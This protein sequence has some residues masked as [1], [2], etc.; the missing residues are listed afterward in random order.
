[1]LKVAMIGA[2][3]Y[4]YELIK[5]MWKIPDKYK[6]IAVSSSL[7][8]QSVGKS[9]CIAKGVEIY[10]NPDALLDSVKGRADVIFV[11]TPIHTHKSL[12]IKCIDA[13]F[14]VF[15][16]KPPVATIQD[17]DE[18]DTYAKSRG[19]RIAVM[20][21][22]LYTSIMIELKKLIV[23]GELG[24]VK[25]IRGV[26]AWPRLEDYFGRNSWAGK[27]NVNDDWI[28]DGTI[29]NPLAHQLSN[30]LYLASS[31]SNRMAEPVT[32]TAE[33][34]HGHDIQSEDTSS[35]RIITDE[36]VEVI[37]NASLCSSETIDPTVVVECERGMIE[38]S[39]FNRAVITF[40]NGVSQKIVDDTEQRIYMLESL[41]DSY[42]SNKEFAC[43]LGKCRP[44][45]L[46]VNAA[47]ESCGKPHGIAREEIEK[48]EQG[49]NI[50]KVIKGI[51]GLLNS[52]HKQGK[53]FSEIGTKWSVA[54]KAFC[55]EDYTKFPSRKLGE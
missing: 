35:L 1:M 20:F 34:Y 19:K 39:N 3:G 40:N 46:A 6:L 29:N 10:P 50:K 53:L 16:E 27:L 11:P 7:E 43:C 24:K 4:A 36:G 25:R 55:T 31:K 47:F 44:F 18:L 12:S 13:G 21:Q 2:G 5:R 54:S 51:D 30:E 38:Y 23:A 49:D 14:D 32:V 17:I 37:F 48:I 52:A 15:L 9:A 33:L 26:A 28:L 41:F 22:S 8:R 42:I 45:T